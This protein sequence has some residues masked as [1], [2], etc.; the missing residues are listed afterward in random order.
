VRKSVTQLNGTSAITISAPGYY[1]GGCVT[2]SA[3]N[4]LN[5][6]AVGIVDIR[7]LLLPA[8]GGLIGINYTGSG[9]LRLRNVRGYGFNA[10]S[11]I[12]VNFAPSVDSKLF[13]FDCEFSENQWDVLVKPQAGAKGQ[14]LLKRLYLTNSMI[15]VRA[16]G[17]GNTAEVDVSLHD[18]V[19]AGHA[20]YSVE[21]YSVY[22]C[23]TTV[24]IDDKTIREYSATGLHVEGAPAPGEPASDTAYTVVGDAT[25]WRNGKGIDNSTYG[26]LSFSYGD[27]RLIGNYPGGDG[28]FNAVPNPI[29]AKA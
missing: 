15:G 9:V 26:G 20:S 22:G 14:A 13:M 18:C 24:L 27:N 4:A 7:N 2:V 21:S 16:D 1:D 10:G 28:A 8:T 23:P 6:T 3:D 19:V 29:L 5:I 11:G 17:S 25:I 12:A